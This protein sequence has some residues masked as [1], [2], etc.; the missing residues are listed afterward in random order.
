V[1]HRILPLLVS[2]GCVAAA[3]SGGDEPRFRPSTAR[4]EG[5]PPA[6]APPAAR[7]AQPQPDPAPG[8]EETE[9]VPVEGAGEG[10]IVPVQ[11]TDPRLLSPSQATERA[12]AQFVAELSTAEGPIRIEVHREWA[13]NGA[14][15]FYNLVRMGYFTDVAFFR[16]VSGFMAQGGI[17]GDPRVS[18]AWRGANIPDDPVVQH[19]T[20]G[21]VSYAMAG[22]GTRTTQ[23][24]I[25]LVDNSRLDGMGFA[26]FGRVL[27]MAPVDRLYSGY[28][29][30]QPSGRGPMQQR[31]QSEGN[32]YLR[33]GFPELDYITSARIAPA[34]Q[35]GR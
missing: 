7:P 6:E 31:L 27:D 17:H 8:V 4:A 15:R 13:P 35:R 32:A 24:F 2:V 22:P 33:A 28:G 11:A 5:R 20:R 3:C 16:V 14:D 18:A 30:S 29:E 19:N 12:P 26:P 25:N 1:T 34:G 21:M 10:D 9:L 23:F